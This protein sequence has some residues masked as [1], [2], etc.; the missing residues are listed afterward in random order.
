M[1]ASQLVRE[2]PPHWET[3]EVSPGRL[4]T[5]GHSNH[6]LTTFLGLLQQ[7]DIEVLVDTR[8]QP[9]SRYVP[10]FNT[11]PLSQALIQTGIQYLGLGHQLGG[12]PR[13]PALYDDRGRVD[14]GLLAASRP[15]QVGLERIRLGLA[16]FRV[17]ILCSEENPSRCHRGRLISRLLTAEMVAVQ[18]IRGDGRL[19]D[20]LDQPRPARRSPRPA[21][22][23]PL[24]VRWP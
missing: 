14:Y 19:Q 21:A 2:L 8:S 17:A 15:F 13:D 7:H 23:L 11:R 10:H 24:Q 20:H 3:P 1:S 6:P 9:Y 22:F 5:I 12:R 4:F 16:H 18:H